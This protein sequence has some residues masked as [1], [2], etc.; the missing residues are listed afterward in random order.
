MEWTGERAIP[1]CAG[2]HPRIMHCHLMR[3]AWATRLVAN[4]TV[5]DIGCGS[6]YGS[7]MLSWVAKSVIGIDVDQE[8]IDYAWDRFSAKNL[9]FRQ[10]DAT[11]EKM[12]FADVYV[13]F[14]V[15]EHLDDPHIVVQRYRPLVWSVP[16]DN[17]NP[18][19]KHVYQVP[20]IKA[21]VPGARGYQT[22]EGNITGEIPD[23]P[24]FGYV[25]GFA[26]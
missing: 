6:G 2:M 20:Q 1:W 24:H 21:L 26:E 22:S 23:K 16:V 13:C 19:H 15:L 5:C 8:A 9:A 10:M 4:K 7:F 11:A 3:Y 18:F 17:A 12:P 25:L 14:E